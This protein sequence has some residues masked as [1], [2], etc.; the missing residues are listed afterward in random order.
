MEAQPQYAPAYQV[1]ARPWIEGRK[2]C[3]ATASRVNTG[4]VYA[5][6][7]RIFAGSM[8]AVRL[9]VTINGVPTSSDCSAFIQ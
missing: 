2:A 9:S 7:A 5:M 1:R 3:A 6:R 4:W 8:S